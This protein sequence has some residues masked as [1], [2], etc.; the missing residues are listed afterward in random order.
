MLIP[1]TVPHHHQR[2]WVDVTFRYEK[3]IY[4][5]APGEVSKY[6]LKYARVRDTYTDEDVA[7]DVR[8]TVTGRLRDGV[9]PRQVVQEVSEIYGIPPACV[10]SIVEE[11]AAEV[12][13]SPQPSV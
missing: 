3:Y 10:D 8:R 12:I 6:L 4:A 1:V 2:I 7:Y 5:D 13:S 9:S 11:V